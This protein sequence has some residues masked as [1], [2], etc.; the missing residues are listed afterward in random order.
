MTKVDTVTFEYEHCG[1]CSNCDYKDSEYY[2]LKAERVLDG[3]W[4]GI[5]DWCPLEDKKE[6]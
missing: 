3:I 1:E 5:P 4:N 6:S 2:C